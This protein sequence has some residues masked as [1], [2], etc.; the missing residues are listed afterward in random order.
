MEIV[1]RVCMCHH[2]YSSLFAMQEKLSAQELEDVIAASAEG[3][4]FPAN[5]DNDSPLGGMAPES[6]RS[7]V[8]EHSTKLGKLLNFTQPSLP[9]RTASVVIKT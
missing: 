5:L 7:L 1:D 3:Y 8:R 4:A 2:I 6:Q 9:S